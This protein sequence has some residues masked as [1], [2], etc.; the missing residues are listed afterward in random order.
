MEDVVIER[1]A[2]AVWAMLEGNHHPSETV[3]E[4]DPGRSVTVSRSLRLGVRAFRT[5]TIEAVDAERCRLQVEVRH[6]PALA[7][8][9]FR[10][11]ATAEEKAVVAEVTALAGRSRNL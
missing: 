1:A 3:V 7:R 8:V 11:H 2:P 9:L 4:T 5:E 6:T 10:K